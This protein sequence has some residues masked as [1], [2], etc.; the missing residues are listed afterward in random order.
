[1]ATVTITAPPDQLDQ[2]TDVLGREFHFRLRRLELDKLEAE[3]EGAAYPLVRMRV[4]AGLR[5]FGLDGGSV[6]LR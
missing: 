6:E 5:A 4:E 3:I 1:V 2:L